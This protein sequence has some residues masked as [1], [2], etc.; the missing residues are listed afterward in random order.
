MIKVGI[1]GA[2]GYV[3]IELIRILLNH[4]KVKIVY[5]ATHSH[6]GMPLSQVYPHL[7]SLLR[8]QCSALDIEE[9]AKHCDL[10]FTA[11]PHGHA[12]KI[13]Q[14]IL[15]AGK[16]LI[17]LGADF[18]LKSPASYEKWYPH[19]SASLELLG[20]AVYGLPELGLRDK[21]KNADL[22]ANPGCYPICSALALMPAIAAA[23]IKTEQIILDAKS[24]TSGAGRGLALDSHFCEVAQN[25]KAYGV[26]G[27]HRHTP[28]IEQ[29]LKEIAGHP[30]I[31]QFTPHLLPIVRGLLVTAYLPLKKEMSAEEIWKIY[32]HAYQDEPFVRLHPLGKFPQ[33]AN[34]RG[35]NYC[36]IGLAIDRRTQRLIIISCI[37]NLVKG[38]AGQAVQNMNLMFSLPETMGLDHLCPA[39]P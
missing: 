12:L 3:G 29:V 17:D 6:V 10:I 37:D 13:A 32:S 7:Q 34:V 4:P 27:S 23:L 31:V 25:F 26:A 39:Y 30:I 8:L 35:S 33:T 38:A 11:L 14:P 18:R 20:K 15:D 1:A 22:I 36:D 9:M 19:P 28:E 2:T 24:G 16:K 21:I 5:A